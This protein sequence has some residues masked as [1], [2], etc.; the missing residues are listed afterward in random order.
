[1]T[2]QDLLILSLPSPA[3]LSVLDKHS[4][5]ENGAAGPPMDEASRAKAE[6]R[7][8]NYYE[9]YGEPEPSAQGTAPFE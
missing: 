1:M 7:Y 9:Y 4:I 2:G 6:G 5:K 3:S 8:P